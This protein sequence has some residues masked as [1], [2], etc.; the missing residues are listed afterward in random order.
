MCLCLKVDLG[1]LKG[2][3]YQLVSWSILSMGLHLVILP[4]LA[5]KTNINSPLDV[6]VKLESGLSY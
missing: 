5:L 6:K 4:H 3:A 2:N 1:T